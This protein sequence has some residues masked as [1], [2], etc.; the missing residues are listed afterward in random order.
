MDESILLQNKT[1]TER[2]IRFKI[3]TTLKKN[4]K[5][6]LPS[7]SIVGLSNQKKNKNVECSISPVFQPVKTL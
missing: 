1:K 7:T 2:T 4:R 6:T 3:I 5:E